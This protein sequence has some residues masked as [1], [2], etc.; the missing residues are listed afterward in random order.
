VVLVIT[1]APDLEVFKRTG[2]YLCK[3]EAGNLL[4]VMLRRI[5]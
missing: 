5:H 1:G 2:V 3:R 4:K